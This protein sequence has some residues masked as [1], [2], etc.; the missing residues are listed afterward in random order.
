MLNEGEKR[1]FEFMNN[2]SGSFYNHLFQ[3]MFKADRTNLSK[4]ELSFPEEVKAVKRYQNEN[5]YW[6]KL[7]KEYKKQDPF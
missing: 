4:L 6:D 1:L 5:G 3:A 2:M 7:Q